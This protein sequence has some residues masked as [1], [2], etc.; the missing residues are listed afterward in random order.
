MDSE[1]ADVL[2]AKIYELTSQVM[3]LPGKTMGLLGIVHGKGECSIPC[4]GIEQERP[5]PSYNAPRPPADPQYCNFRGV[6]LGLVHAGDVA[7][8]SAR[9][10]KELDDG[11]KAIAQRL[12]PRGTGAPVTGTF[13]QATEEINRL[14][15]KVALRVDPVPGGWDAH[16]P[17]FRN[18]NTGRYLRLGDARQAHLGKTPEGDRKNALYYETFFQ[19]LQFRGIDVEALP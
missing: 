9:A 7:D 12:V 10:G 3:L 11:L 17:A 2:R 13:P 16:V 6:Y 5:P 8:L 18:P 4:I 1:N 15:N 19:L 14:L